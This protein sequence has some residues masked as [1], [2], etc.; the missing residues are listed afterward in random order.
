[1]RRETLLLEAAIRTLTACGTA[2][3]RPSEKWKV[4]A[5]NRIVDFNSLYPEN[6]SG[7]HGPDGKGGVAIGLSN[8]V[9]RA[10]ADAADWTGDYPDRTYSVPVFFRRMR[11]ELEAPAHSSSY[12]SA[13]CRGVR[14]VHAYGRRCAMESGNGCPERR[15]H[16]AQYL[17]GRSALERQGA[18]VF[19][20]KQC[21]NCHPLGNVGGQRG[22]ELDRVAVQFT[23]GQLIRQVIQGGGNMPAYGKNLSPVETTALVAF[24]ETLHPAGQ[25]QAQDAARQ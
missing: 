22:P 3:G 15:T 10:I 11:E 4:L 13:G 8:P 16:P 21:H 1:M 5:P 2:P 23:R 20:A 7:C 6:C 14:H 18:L 19:Q 12:D 25:P 24:L 9:Y 17:K